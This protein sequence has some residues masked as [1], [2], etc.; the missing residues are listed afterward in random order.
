[1]ISAFRAL[2]ITAASEP[3][4][5]RKWP[6][7]QPPPPGGWREEGDSSQVLHGSSPSTHCLGPQAPATGEQPT[8]SLR[9]GRRREVGLPCLTQ[10]SCSQE[11]LRKVWV[12]RRCQT[13]RWP[14]GWI[15][16][17]NWQHLQCPQ[18]TT[19]RSWPGTVAFQGPLVLMRQ[20]QERDALLK[21]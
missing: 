9:D 5:S 6:G 7:C 20:L 15:L 4:L 16:W 3:S 2:S 8:W 12:P 19:Y 1:M 17:E 14:M 11:T 10:A 21:I 13:L 18:V